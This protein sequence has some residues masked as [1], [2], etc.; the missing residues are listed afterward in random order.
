[1]SE[2]PRLA[3]LPREEWDDDARDALAAAFSEEVAQR[4]LAD[5][6]DAPPMPNVLGTLMRHPALA[7]PFLAY[8]QAL[9]QSPALDA[10]QREL[11][12]LRVAWRTR[13]PYEWAQHVRMAERVGITNEELQAIAGSATDTWT[14]LEADLLAATDQLIDRYRIDDDTWARLAEHLDE[15]QLVELVFVVGTYTGLAMAFNSF[16]LQ[17][18]PE[19]EAI[20]GQRTSRVRG[21]GNVQVREARRGQLDRALPGARDRAGLVRGLHLAR[22]LRARARGDLQALVAQRRTGRAAASARAAT[23]R[24]SSQ[25]PTRR[26]SS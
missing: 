8:N 2:A 10:R 26:S 4:F 23:S 20:V 12:I 19:L 16:G 7:G 6:P 15:R 5:G 1:M 13:A 9:L 18:D 24:R 22:D 17:L 14:P 11:M 21:V 3:P 25:S